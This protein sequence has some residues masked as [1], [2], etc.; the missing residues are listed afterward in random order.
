MARVLTKED[1]LLRPHL[2]EFDREHPSP[3]LSE[4]FLD[5]VNSI[6]ADFSAEELEWLN[7]YEFFIFNTFDGTWT[8]RAVPGI[9]RVK[10][11]ETQYL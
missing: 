8:E 6:Q 9:R 5:Y 2:I 10:R 11:I 3:K 7:N 4:P 1:E